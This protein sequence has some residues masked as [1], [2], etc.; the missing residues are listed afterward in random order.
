MKKIIRIF[1][2]VIGVLILI[3]TFKFLWDSSR[4]ETPMYEI[5]SPKIG[6]IK[7]TTTATGNIEP[8]NE[9]SVKP[10]IPGIISSIRKEVGDAVREGEI[11]ATLRVIPDAAQLSS[12]ESRVRLAEITLEQVEK[13]YE[14]QKGLYEK[15]VIS[16]NDYEVIEASYEKAIEEKEN[17][18]DALQIVRTGSSKNPNLANNTQVRSRTSG[19]ILDIPVKVG[20]SV[21]NSN[22]FTDGTT[23]AVVADMNDLIFSG[24]VDE[25]EIGKIKEG[26]HLDISVGAITNETIE[27]TL[28]YIAPRGKKESGSVLYEIKAAVKTPKTELIRANYS[29][30]ANIVTEE[31]KDVITV[32]ESSVEFSKSGLTYVYILKSNNSQK[33]IFVKRPIEIGLSDGVNLQV[34]SGLTVSDQIRGIKIEKTK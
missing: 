5:I 29:A 21:M 4:P 20:N 26:M 12:A 9:I 23:I 7:N 15:D 28:E 10:E 1:L 13:Q 33:Q 31:A 19:T 2:L 25:V 18:Q 17:A 16:R 8:R 32:P 22:G 27:A 14:R 6:D 11:I 3:A 24:T 34:V 30:N